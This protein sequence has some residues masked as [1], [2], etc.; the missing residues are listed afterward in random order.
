MKQQD[1]D[2]HRDQHRQRKIHLVHR[3]LGLGHQIFERQGTGAE[4][5][6]DQDGLARLIV[7]ADQDGGQN[8]KRS[9]PVCDLPQHSHFSTKIG[10]IHRESKPEGLSVGFDRSTKGFNFGEFP[11]LGV[12]LQQTKHSKHF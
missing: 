4:H 11:M 7:Q 5:E 9:Q 6:T 10:I 3:F 8:G 1:Q 12:P 2:D